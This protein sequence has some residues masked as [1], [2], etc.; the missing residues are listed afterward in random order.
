MTEPGRGLRRS[1]VVYDK[2]TGEVVGVHQVSAAEG[3]SL[4]PT[5]D[6]VRLV[7]RA[8]ITDKGSSAR[9]AVL[10]HESAI[11]DPLRYSVNLRTGRLVEKRRA[12]PP[13]GV[14]RAARRR[15]SPR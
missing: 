6:L 7:L 13:A 9:L 10:E 2:R 4:P 8:A 1:F 12:R 14:S 5:N 15:R 11:A 3:T